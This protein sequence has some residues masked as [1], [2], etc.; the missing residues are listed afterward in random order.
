LSKVFNDFEVTHQ[1]EHIGTR[2]MVL[3]ARRLEQEPAR[4]AFILLA[5]EDITE[6]KRADERFRLVVEAAPNAMIM[7]GRDG[8]INLVN[9]QVEPLFGYT[10]EELL[11]QPI[12]ILVPQRLRAEHPAYRD[13]FFEDP[14]ARPMGAGRDLFGVRK[15]GSEVPIEI[16]LNPI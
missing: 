15:D 3:N 6:R 1:F 8:K 9:K 5:M 14:R 13:S 16:G 10:R 11:G 12:E 2:T 4:L 7:V